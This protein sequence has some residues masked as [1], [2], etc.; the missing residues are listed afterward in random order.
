MDFFS[1]PI[2]T[3]IFN[4]IMIP[5]QVIIIFFTFYYFALAMFGLYRKKER[6]ILTPEKSFALVVAAHNEEKVIGPLVE[7]LLQME[8][9]KELYDV[10]VVADNCVDKT[11][12]IA[13]NAG[14]MVHQ[15]F[16]DTKKGK[17]YALEWMFHR[18]F[19]LE[20]QYDAVIIFDADNLV[21]ENFLIE[22]NS[23]L[24]QG[25]R[26]IQCYLDSKNP[27]DTWVTNTF[28]ISFW[29]TN[30]LLQLARFN[31][32]LSNVLGGTGMCISTDVLRKF[33]WGATSLTEDLEF[34]MKA[35]VHGVKTTW[36]HDAVVYDEKPLTFAQS[37]RQRKRW[38]QGQVDVAGRYFFTLL[39]KG[40]RERKLTY[41]DASVH[42]FQPALVML[43]T[44]FMLINLVSAFQTHYTH[45]FS[46]VM[47]WSGWQILSA[48]QYLYPVVALTLDRL[49]WR[50]YLGLIL[51]PVFIYSWIPIVFLGFLRRND[52]Q[53]SH[54][55]HTR[56]ISYD[57]VI[58]QKKV[59]TN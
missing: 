29:L 55:Q 44:F 17:G 6:K 48:F 31:I 53:W 15:R 46:L 50:S 8:Y 57:E 37:W 34:S 33:G 20:R 59:S 56:S 3:D 35:L 21:K 4:V 19:K 16:N 39:F 43:A 12:L 14:A 1:G 30:R 40:F 27:F 22:M 18:L 5:V 2:G 25:D 23:K 58:R 51:Y 52:K 24:C 36:A 11:A 41:I 45:I 47:P 13:R 26:I 28:S 10:F 49:P 32:G 9:P 54:T 38:A 7:N 42:L